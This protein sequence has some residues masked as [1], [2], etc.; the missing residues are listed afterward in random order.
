M[1]TLVIPIPDSSIPGAQGYRAESGI[2][3][4]DGFIKNRYI[5]RS[6]SPPA[7][8]CGDNAVRIK[9]NP[10]KDNVAGKRLSSSRTRS[11]GPRR[12]ARRCGCCAMS[13]PPRSICGCSRRRTGGPASTAWTPPTGQQLI[14]AH[15]GVDE[16]REYLGADSLAYL[17]LDAM[18]DAITPRA[19]LASAR[20]A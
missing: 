13:A 6:S 3:Y 4:G 15:R 10:I 14:A 17:D 16:I 12:C 11:Y 20:R 8:S 19:G 7:R 1:P 18:L 5:G 2:P 9:L